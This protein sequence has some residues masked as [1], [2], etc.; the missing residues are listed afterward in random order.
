MAKSSPLLACNW[1]TLN[2]YFMSDSVFVPTV[3]LWAF[4]FQRPPQKR[5]K[6]DAHCTQSLTKMKV[7]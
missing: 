3:L 6:I 5:M 1:L 2:G 4:N 7:N